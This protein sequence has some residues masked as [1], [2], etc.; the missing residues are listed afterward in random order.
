MELWSIIRLTLIHCGV[1]LGVIGLFALT[2]YLC[3]LFF[4][5]DSVAVWWFKKVDLILAIIAPT[6]L[7]LIFLSSLLR[8]VV[9]AIILAWKGFPDVNKH[10]ILA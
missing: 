5:A 1:A 6:A 4:P 7:A 2:L 10:S 3:G 9:D 8:I